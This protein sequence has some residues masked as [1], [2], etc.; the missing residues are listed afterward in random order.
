MSCV[1]LVAHVFLHSGKHSDLDFCSSPLGLVQSY[2]HWLKQASNLG[3]CLVPLV[4]GSVVSL[5]N[6][7]VGKRR[8]AVERKEALDCC[9]HGTCRGVFGGDGDQEA[10][11]LILHRKKQRRRKLFII[12]YCILSTVKRMRASIDSKT[13]KVARCGTM[14]L[15]LG[16]LRLYRLCRYTYHQG[17]DMR[18][19]RILLLDVRI[20]YTIYVARCHADVFGHA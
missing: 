8:A 17:R 13:Q 7:T 15:W 12:V 1:L 16:I 19:W 9:V 11:R 4:L 20:G 10:A 3:S 14:G 5:A 6:T 2:M 18:G